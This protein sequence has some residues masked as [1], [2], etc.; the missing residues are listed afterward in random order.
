MLIT[1]D[2]YRLVSLKTLSLCRSQTLLYP[3]LWAIWGSTLCTSLWDDAIQSIHPLA[4]SCKQKM[5]HLFT[6]QNWWFNLHHKFTAKFINLLLN[7]LEKTTIYRWFICQKWW[8]DHSL[9]WKI[10]RGIE[11]T[12]EY[13]RNASCSIA[14]N[15]KMSVCIPNCCSPGL[16][17]NLWHWN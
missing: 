5:A 13:P 7:D 16:P 1:L 17:Q 14:Q 4:R 3:G 9:M 8:F 11:T 12:S 2:I 10:T 15:A 6:C